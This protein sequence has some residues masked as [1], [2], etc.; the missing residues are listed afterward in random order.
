MSDRGP[1]QY[2]C[3]N[4]G[5]ATYEHGPCD[6][7]G[8]G[9]YERD[10]DLIHGGE[11]PV[12]GDEFGDGF[13]DISEGDQID[14]ARICVIEKNDDGTEMADGIIHLPSEIAGEVEHE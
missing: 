13:G 14:G 5:A 3:G 8:K 11:C 7:C 4:C 6:E 2:E 10:D 12:C 9:P 1:K